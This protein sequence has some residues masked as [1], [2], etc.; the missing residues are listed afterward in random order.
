MNLLQVI[1]ARVQATTG[2][3]MAEFHGWIDQSYEPLGAGGDTAARLCTFIS[4]YVLG[5]TQ[6]ILTLCRCDRVSGVHQGP[7]RHAEVVSSFK[8]RRE[9][10]NH[11]CGQRSNGFW[12]QSKTVAACFGFRVMCCL[13]FRAIWRDTRHTC[14]MESYGTASPPAGRTARWWRRRPRA[15]GSCPTTASAHSPLTTC[16]KLSGVK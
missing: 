3:S 2:M 10:G 9:V 14:R 13:S 7:V 1:G 16:C 8:Q 15:F 4:T 12:L 6:T 11:Y 5:R